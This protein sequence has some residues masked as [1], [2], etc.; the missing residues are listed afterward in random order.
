M[1]RSIYVL[2]ATLLISLIVTSILHANCDIYSRERGG[3][4]L[5]LNLNWLS[6]TI[7]T[8]SQWWPVVKSN[9][10]Q[11]QSNYNNHA[12]G[13]ADKHSAQHITYSGSVT[14]A[15]NVKEGLDNLKSRVDQI[16]TTPIDGEAA[17][18]E[19]TDARGGEPT[20]GARFDKIDEHLKN[21]SVNIKDFGAIGDGVTDDT[22]A[23]QA[24]L[25]SITDGGTVLIPAGIYKISYSL[26]VGSNT[27]LVG[28]GR[29]S[30]IKAELSNTLCATLIN[31]NADSVG[32]YDAAENIELRNFAIE[33]N[34]SGIEFAHA[35]D[36]RIYNIYGNCN[37]LVWHFIDLVGVKN[38]VVK[39]CTFINDS[40]SSDLI[41]L[42]TPS[43]ETA[44]AFLTSTLEVKS[45]LVDETSTEDI[46]I[47]ENYLQKNDDDGGLI[48]LH[49]SPVYNIYI[50]NNVLE[51]GYAGVYCQTGN[52]KNINVISNII[53]QRDRD[54]ISYG[55]GASGI[56]IGATTVDNVTIK[57]NVLECCG[58][59][60]VNVTNKLIIENNKISTYY[61]HNNISGTGSIYIQ[62]NKIKTYK[63]TD[64]IATIY[65]NVFLI[66][67]TL[68]SLVIKNNTFDNSL[69][70]TNQTGICIRA[71]CDFINIE[72]NEFNSL[73]LAY[74]NVNV[75]PN[76]PGSIELTASVKTLNV[77]ANHFCN[78]GAG[79]ALAATVTEANNILIRDNTFKTISHP[80]VFKAEIDMD[81]V[82][83][84]DNDFDNI[85]V[86]ILKAN[87]NRTVKL[88]NAVVS[89]NVFKDVKSYCIYLQGTEIE[90]E[91][92]R[93]K[94][95]NGDFNGHT[96]ACPI[97][98][99]ANTTSG[100]II[101]LIS[102]NKFLA[103]NNKIFLDGVAANN[104]IRVLKNEGDFTPY[105]SNML[106][107]ISEI[108]PFNVFSE[109]TNKVKGTKYYDSTSN[110]WKFW[111]GSAWT[112]M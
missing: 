66:D 48:T 17:A 19:L 92:E 104:Y 106:S 15:N 87:F 56:I 36:I 79:V 107:H 54:E 93:N 18:Q 83:I 8:L 68:T 11:I 21:I 14:G 74:D 35:K 4:M 69:G 60:A 65:R 75:S 84:I 58:I 20:I 63:D 44:A 59:T 50:E 77:I 41:Q 16:I 12:D 53:R 64:D 37:T 57:D 39:G 7:K 96:T 95:L 88:T 49:R 13:T 100:I 51:Y 78:G 38:V 31:K 67:G 52:Y 26:L 97:L 28:Q 22:A 103:T 45:A 46:Y 71:S 33:S 2:I 5:N 76:T 98:I 25:D 91:F 94:I 32:G 9:F 27:T 24:A 110:V 105:F 29:K 62:N 61:K 72:S 112:T 86:G 23:I 99:Q 40:S 73:G 109:P 70:D 1:K 102:N 90:L 43:A 10:Q 82:R 42:D 3:K 30:I 89:G 47:S 34:A 80:V 108:E 6:D 101:A 55:E 81:N 85:F 111:N